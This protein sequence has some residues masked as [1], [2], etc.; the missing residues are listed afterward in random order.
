MAQTTI[1]FRIDEGLKHDF[2]RLCED[3]GMNLT[4]AF[5]VFAKKATRE[6]R[7]PFE[8]SG[9]PFYS[10]KNIMH[11]EQVIAD[12]ENGRTSVI[13]KTMTELE[14]MENA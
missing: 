10:R 4:T 11:L 9:D 7:I 8:L 3:L 5:T 14:A 1:N 6:N 12:Y 2:E 13:A